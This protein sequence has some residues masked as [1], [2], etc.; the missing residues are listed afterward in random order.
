MK[1]GL[2]VPS[3]QVFDHRIVVDL[4]WEFLETVVDEKRAV[5][6]D[7]VHHAELFILLPFLFVSSLLI[8]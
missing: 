4:L 5:L 3:Q 7:L 1:L 6:Q 2:F 8:A